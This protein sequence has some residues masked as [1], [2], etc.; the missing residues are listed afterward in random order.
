V[1]QGAYDQQT[2]QHEQ[3]LPAGEPVEAPPPEVMPPTP[4]VEE[5]PPADP[6]VDLLIPV[7]PASV[8]AAPTARPV[9]LQ[10]P[11]AVGGR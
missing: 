9:D 2:L 8:Q 1:G 7:Q 11:A 10:Q 4:P 3:Y 6:A 5:P